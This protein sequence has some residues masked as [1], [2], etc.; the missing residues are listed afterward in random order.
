MSH[1]FNESVAKIIDQFN[2]VLQKIEEVET[3][4]IVNLKSAVTRYI[5]MT[6]TNLD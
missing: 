2:H 5:K 3:K 6:K 4:K 1:R